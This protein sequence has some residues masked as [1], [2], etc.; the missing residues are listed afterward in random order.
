MFDENLD[1]TVSDPSTDEG[2]EV[3]ED[4]KILPKDQPKEVKTVPYER[5]REVNEEL[6]KLKKQKETAPVKEEYSIGNI[7]KDA[8]I[9]SKYDDTES[10]LIVEESKLRGISI[11]EAEKLEFLQNAITAK[12]EKVEREKTVPSPSANPNTGTTDDKI[13]TMS[14]DDHRKLEEDFMRKQKSGGAGV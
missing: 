2:G 13:A 4:V 8:K 1:E 14:R 9:L 10:E 6:A 11:S 7:A 5:F 3:K 12:R